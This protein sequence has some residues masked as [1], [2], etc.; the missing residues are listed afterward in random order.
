M[1]NLNKRSKCPIW[2]NYPADINVNENTSHVYIKDSPRAG[3][4]F[5]INGEAMNDIIFS[6][7]DDIQKA[8]LTTI[9]VNQRQIGNKCPM[10]TIDL[11]ERAKNA[12]ALPVYER[13][14]R[15]L[16][17][18]E[19]KTQTVDD[20]IC[21]NWEPAMV[22]IFDLGAMAWTE[23]TKLEE[24]QYLL[25]YLISRNLVSDIGQNNYRIT[26]D[27]YSYI[28]DFMKNVDSNQSFVAMWF[29]ENMTEPFEKGIEPAVLQAGYKPLRID[30]KEHINKID[31]EIIA[32]IR[33][34]KFIIADF[35]QGDDGAR[36]GV[37]Y[38]AGFAHGLDLPVIF[39]CHKDSIN[40]LHFDTS[41]YNHIVWDSPE[42]LREKLKNRILARFGEG[43]YPNSS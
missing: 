2:Q 38:E 1:K 33:R 7:L 3:G 11:I 16:R 42:D 29:D 13:A 40:N 8:K 14:N 27:G 19:L 26:V 22:N 34:S 35:T 43:V 37:Y 4:K 17:F 23:S 12:T 41:H 6:P 32:E 9:L 24:V 25:K 10:V 5:E 18:M 20:A 21:L 31:D 36:G 39:T 30:K 15:L 28:T